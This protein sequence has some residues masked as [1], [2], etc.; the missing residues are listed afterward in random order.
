ML[1]DRTGS[2]KRPAEHIGTL[3]WDAR[4]NAYGWRSFLGSEPGGPGVPAR[5]VPARLQDMR[6]L[7]PAFIAVGGIDL[8]VDED[9]DYARSEEHTS[10]L[11]S[12]MRN[13]Y[14]VFCLTK[15]INTNCTNIP[16]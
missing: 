12:L 8:F 10:E 14:A 9:I 11:Q 2:P 13:S 7:A 16:Q 15:K 3:L 1:D 5:A 6:G 4:A